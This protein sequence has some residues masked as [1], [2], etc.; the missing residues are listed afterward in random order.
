MITE[1][2][3]K[4]FN[5]TDNVFLVVSVIQSSFYSFLL[6]VKIQLFKSHQY[7]VD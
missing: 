6:D 4:M 2:R 1:L 3:V 5:T 7:Y